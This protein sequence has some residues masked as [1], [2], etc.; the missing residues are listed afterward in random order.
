MK[1]RGRTLPTK[2]AGNP[3]KGGKGWGLLLL[4]PSLAAEGFH[5]HISFPVPCAPAL[6]VIGERRPAHKRGD[7]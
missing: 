1:F 5:S 2:L 7:I 3:P 6:S 4:L